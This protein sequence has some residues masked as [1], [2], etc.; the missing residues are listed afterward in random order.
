MW[1]KGPLDT[2][3]GSSGVMPLR[4]AEG[5]T[6]GHCHQGR[7]GPGPQAESKPPLPQLPG[8]EA[9]LPCS[10]ADV[11]ALPSW[12]TSSSLDDMVPLDDIRSNFLKSPGQEI[13]VSDTLSQEEA[14]IRLPRRFPKGPLHHPGRTVSSVPSQQGRSFT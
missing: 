2:V 11:P 9:P 5:G 8:S 3:T 14:G 10:N 12:S 6:N 4:S 7:S 1:R 13:G